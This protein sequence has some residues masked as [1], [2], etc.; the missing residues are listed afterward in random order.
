[1]GMFIFRIT[2]NIQK[3]KNNIKTHLSKI[4]QKHSTQQT[5]MK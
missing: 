1:M 5:W 4:E 3:K 2:Y